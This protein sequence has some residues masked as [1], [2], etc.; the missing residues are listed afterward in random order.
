MSLALL[1]LS[2][3]AAPQS[4]VHAR[5]EARVE[6]ASVA[7]GGVATVV[8]TFEID[9]GW[10]VYAPDQDPE[11]GTPTTIELVGEGVEA[12]GPTTV[13]VE[14]KV[15][16]EEL[17][18]FSITTL[19]VEGRPE[20][21]LPVRVSGEPG[22]RTFTARV[23]WMECDPSL[24]LPVRTQDFPLTLRVVADGAAAAGGAAA[25]AGG[26]AGS[27]AAAQEPT[28][29][30]ELAEDFEVGPDEKVAIE[31]AFPSRLERGETHDLVVEMEVAEGWHVYHP[32]QDPELGEPVSV[33]LHGEGLELVGPVMTDAKPKRKRESWGDVY[34]WL[35][36]D[37]EFRA[38]VRVVGDP[39]TARAE[40]VVKYQVCND[41]FCLA[42]HA[43]VFSIGAGSDAG[44]DAAALLGLDLG[45]G[46]WSFLLA[47]ML[48]GFLTLLTPCVFPMIPVTISYFTKR[49]ETGKGTPL[50]N[51]L[52]YAGGIVFTFAGIGVGAALLLGPTGA[53][54]I[55]SNPWVNFAIGV[56]FIVMAAS[57]LGF[58]EIQPP[59]FLQAFAS[60]AQAEGVAK[61]G[62]L[63]VVLMAIAFSI[64]AFTCTVAFVG[65]VFALG[66]KLGVAYLVL[67]MFVYGLVFALPFFFLALFPNYLQSMPQA[68]TWM[69]TFKASA[70]FVELIAAIKFFSNT[71]LSWRAGILTWPVVI[72]LTVLLLLLWALYLFGVYR[73]PH[74]HERVRP[75]KRRLAVGVFVLLLAVYMAPGVWKRPYEAYPGL[76]LAYLPPADYGFEEVAEDGGLVKAGGMSF[77]E[78]YGQAYALALAEGKPLFVDFTGVTCVNCRR[79]E[80][81]I[82]PHEEVLP[83][84]QRFVRAELWVDRDPHAKWNADY[85]VERFGFAAQPFYVLLDP[86]DDAVLAR[87]PGYDPDP[88]AF[89]AFLREG[90]EAHAE[91]TPG[92]MPE[93]GPW[94]LR[95]PPA[96]GWGEWATL[97]EP[98]SGGG[99]AETVPGDGAAGE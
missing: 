34:L 11:W 6:P 37:L 13:S 51:A 35:S 83:L 45:G 30:E 93:G 81:E 20:F 46:L 55:G 89:A 9:P 23:T 95:K 53:N 66:L 43:Q 12:D 29:R 77:F 56:L 62:Y 92:P 7:P 25:D 47:A 44:A 94:H 85:E 71:D 36:G 52:A 3:L 38:P 15:H 65:L 76:L 1:L 79:M 40:V 41:Q 60:K 96:E 4:D 84:L 61:G 68:G 97:P 72:G 63:P 14:P 50:K 10:H 48:A 54:A 74:D 18:N 49:A 28:W 67:G 17:G 78:D 82:F 33:E 59:R 31:V 69:N 21:R 91:R 42:R 2:A 73:L 58:Y 19:W 75:G 70:G 16:V 26:A 64:T 32:D 88:E 24:C 5:V 99:P 39:A 90:L 86:R 22:E 80:Y 98:G 27:A 87:F 57:L 8:A